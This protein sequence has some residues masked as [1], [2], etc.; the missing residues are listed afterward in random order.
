[1]ERFFLV[2]F[3]DFHIH[4]KY[5]GGTSKKMDLEHLARYGPVKGLNLIGTGDITH[6][7]WFTELKEKLT[8]I[9]DSNLFSFNNMR[10][11]LT[12]EV[13]TVFE[14][15]GTSKQIHHH[16]LVPN[17]EVASQLNDELSRFG[18]LSSDG[19][20]NLRMTPAELIEIMKEID[21]EIECI[22]AHIWTSYFSVLGARGFNCLKDCYQEKIHEIHALETGLSS[23]LVM[24][25]RV[26]ELEKYLFVSNS[27][28]H[29]P[30]PWRIG[31]EANVFNIEELT[32]SNLIEAISKKDTKK[33]PMTI[34]VDPAYGK[35]HFDGHRKNRIYYKDG[36]KLEHEKGIRMHPEFAIDRSNCLCPI[37]KKPFTIG[38]L[39]RV[40]ELTDREEGYKPE[41]AQDFKTL[42]PLSE[43]IAAAKG[44]ASIYAKGVWLEYEKLVNA[45]DNELEVLLN[46]SNDELSKVTTT[47]I[48]ETIL[49]VRQGQIHVDPG[50]DGEYGRLMLEGMLDTN[51]V[52][53]YVPP[54]QKP[55]KTRQVR[56]DEF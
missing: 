17:F 1:M 13:N 44:I 21:R 43:I 40:E 7:D 32:Y 41:T 4:S 10:F 50:Y 34:E 56:L 23:D 15:E 30:W 31:R 29:S 8:S 35:Y 19:R 46:I 3:V 12:G 14:Y 37:C 6:P 45:F 27:D 38:V 42:I 51:D 26:S 25:W 2:F 36:V 52:I 16:F 11:I 55:E 49:K 24:N 54:P 47:E 39:H 18:E 33:F 9:E 22:P 5:S 28:C 20:P 53:N 48:A